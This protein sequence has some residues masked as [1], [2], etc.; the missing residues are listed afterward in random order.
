MPYEISVVVFVE[1]DEQ[2]LEIGNN[3]LGFLQN[4]LEGDVLKT[5]QIGVI[6][7]EVDVEA[8]SEQ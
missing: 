2:A 6:K 5:A 3:V 8:G 4:T 7:R 1:N